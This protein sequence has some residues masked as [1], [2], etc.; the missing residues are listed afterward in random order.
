MQKARPEDSESLTEMAQRAYRQHFSYLWTAEGLENYL[1]TAYQ[2]DLFEKAI[3]EDDNSMI[4]LAIQQEQ[5]CGYLMYYRRKKLPGAEAEGGYI[6]R[7]YL[8]DHCGGQGIGSQLMKMAI[9]QGLEDDVP[10]LWLEVMQSNAASIAF[11]QKQGFSFRGET[12]FTQLP[13]RTV[14]LSRMWWMV[15]ELAV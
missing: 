4:W 8:L 6:N 15:K 1:T 3:R 10:Y 11:Y 13:M 9:Q 12:A 7:I 5:L 14:E 2:P